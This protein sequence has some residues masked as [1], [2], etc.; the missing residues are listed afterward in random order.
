MAATGWA[1]PPEVLFTR[2]FAE[3]AAFTSLVADDSTDGSR[4][5][6]LGGTSVE[7]I[8][9]FYVVRIDSAGNSIWTNRYGSTDRC[10]GITR[11]SNGSIALI[12]WTT[13]NNTV[14][15]KIMRSAADGLLLTNWDFGNANTADVAY[16]LIEHPVDWFLV[17]GKATP[18]I[19]G[20]SDGT[21]LHVSQNG[22]PEWS[23]TYAGAE[24]AC[25]VAVGD[26]NDI[27]VFA[28]ADSLDSLRQHDALII[29]ADSL[30]MIMD[31]VRIGGARDE[32]VNDAL[33]V[34]AATTI[35]VGYSV[36]SLGDQDI[37][38]VG[39]ND[40]GDSLWSRTWGTTADD[41]ALAVTKATDADSGFVIAGWSDGLAAETRSA[42]LM[43]FDQNGDSLWTIAF[44]D[45]SG[46]I[47][48]ADVAQDSNFHYHAV[49]KRNTDFDHGFYIQTDTDP[50]VGGQYP[51][52]H[53][54]LLL[55]DNGDTLTQDTIYFDWETA[56]DPDPG[57]EVLYALLA[58]TDTL[59]V[60]P[61]I[62]GPFAVSHCWWAPPL[63]DVTLYWR[64]SAQDE[65]EHVR[66]CDD[67]QRSLVRIL[68]DSTAA[69][70]LALPDSG[71][72]LTEP[73]TVFSWDRAYDPDLNDTIRYTIHYVTADTSFEISGLQDTFIT[74]NFVDHP[75]IG[76]A[77]TV[78]WYVTVHSRNPVMQRN[79][80]EQWPFMTW[81][82]A[83]GDPT[84]LPLS[85]D[86]RAAYPNPFNASTSLEFSLDRASDV[87]LDVFTIEGRLATTIVNGHFPA[88][89][90]RM[91]W[92]GQID[93]T[94]APSGIYFAR[95]AADEHVETIKLMLLR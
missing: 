39:T 28:T 22:S 84:E 52:N 10:N 16:S 46:N 74:V 8:Y 34:S 82:E 24:R 65:Q 81:S 59:F 62:R 26:S 51:P 55:P 80:R 88:G 38:I 92:N 14:D 37:W 95:L 20:E 30:G 47:E 94:A 56:V 5:W 42:V 86:L 21:L 19:Q 79:S 25:A 2:T 60:D 11:A 4:R 53:F 70:S 71:A 12:G 29:R 76:L 35:L 15:Y 17:T 54:S 41:A 72:I 36:S 91:G 75:V 77:E 58:D 68:P 27:L 32:F 64:V 50:R 61:F 9:Q 6:A 63:D 66:I 3:R 45:T 93:G 23:R 73:F 44:S 48:L 57:D 49:G 90:Y 83:A 43:K 85:F 69:F 13:E 40:N 67:R 31:S 87:H 7:G 18:G 33:R 89:S 1:L 78:E